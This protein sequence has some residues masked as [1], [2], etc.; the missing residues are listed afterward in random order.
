MYPNAQVGL[1]FYVADEGRGAYIK[2]WMLP[3]PAPTDTQ[4]A[5][6]LEAHHQ[7]RAEGR[8]RELR[9]A[10]YPSVTDQLDAMYKA[11]RGAVEDLEQ[12]DALIRDIKCRFPKPG[13]CERDCD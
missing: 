11:R 5:E 2:E 13:D 7:E 6:A 9:K 1:D 3:T 4:L 12:I 10:H 8:Y